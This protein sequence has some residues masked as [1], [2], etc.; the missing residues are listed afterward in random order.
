MFRK[1]PGQ[2]KTEMY[3]PKS[4]FSEI[5]LLGKRASIYVVACVMYGV[6]KKNVSMYVCM[7]V[8]LLTALESTK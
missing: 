6:S 5:H 3:L 2:V 7:Y 4:P 1:C 8:S